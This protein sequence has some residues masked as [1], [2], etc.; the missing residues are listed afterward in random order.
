MEALRPSKYLLAS[1][2]GLP[3]DTLHGFALVR[4]TFVS[5]Q[6]GAWFNHPF[7]LVIENAHIAIKA[8]SQ[9]A[10]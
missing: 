6:H 3:Y 4:G 10:F 1:Q 5:E 8:D 9:G 2:P 7:C